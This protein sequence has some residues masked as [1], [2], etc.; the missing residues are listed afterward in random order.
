MI[1][2][3]P[4]FELIQAYVNGDLPV[5]L[6]AGIAIHAQMCTICQTKIEQFTE[7]LAEVSFESDNLNS[8]NQIKSQVRESPNMAN[9]DAMIDGI[10]Q[11]SDIDVVVP[12]DTYASLVVYTLDG[13]QQIQLFRGDLKANQLY[14]YQFDTSQFSN[15]V[16]IYRLQTKEGV[17]T[18]KLI[19]QR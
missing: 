9:V 19:P 11:C 4:K 15:Q 10:T 13:S 12:N 6:S 14:Q 1:N 8:I 7:Q 18:G 5:S 3:H 16:Y 2:H 17:K